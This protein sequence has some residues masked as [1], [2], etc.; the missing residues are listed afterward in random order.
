MSV[1]PWRPVSAPRWPCPSPQAGPGGDASGPRSAPPEV[2]RAAAHRHCRSSGNY[3]I[4]DG[5]ARK[6]GR[7]REGLATGW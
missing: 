1:S 6:E 7:E 2:A 5:P 3:D 4:G